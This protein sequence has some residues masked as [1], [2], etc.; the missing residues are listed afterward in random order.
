MK[1]NDVPTAENVKGCEI[2]YKLDLVP[3][4]YEN[5][6]TTPLAVPLGCE[7]PLTKRELLASFGYYNNSNL[8]EDEEDEDDTC[9]TDFVRDEFY[10]WASEYELDEEGLP[11]VEKIQKADERL[12]KR[13][14]KAM[15][16]YEKH[17]QNSKE[18]NEEILEQ[19][20]AQVAS[21]EGN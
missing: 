16:F 5:L 18:L 13:M 4:P 14:E 20:P 7:V 10:Q 21:D 15:E 8:Y 1:K 2:F 3:E 19:P 17:S 11:M 9:Q 6:D 12:K